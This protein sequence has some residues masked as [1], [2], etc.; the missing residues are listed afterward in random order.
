[1]P[2]APPEYLTWPTPCAAPPPA[3]PLAPGAGDP[4]PFAIT[5]PDDPNHE[6]PPAWPRPPP[7]PTLTVHCCPGVTAST[8]RE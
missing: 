3:A 7:A 8:E 2:P 1:M 4:P 6:S 5:V